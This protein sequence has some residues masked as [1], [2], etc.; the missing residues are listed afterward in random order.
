[1]TRKTTNWV[2]DH[3]DRGEYTAPTYFVCRKFNGKTEWMRSA[4]SGRRVPFASQHIA[5]MAASDLNRAI[6]DQVPQC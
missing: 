6:S 4:T 1:M 2:V 3:E 5:E